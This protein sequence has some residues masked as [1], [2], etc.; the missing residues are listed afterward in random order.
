[1]IHPTSPKLA[2]T[3]MNHPYLKF[4]THLCCVC[5]PAFGCCV[6]PKAGQTTFLSRFQLNLQEKDEQAIVS[7]W[8]TSKDCE[9]DL[10]LNYKT[11]G[12]P[13]AFGGIN[14]IYK[15]LNLRWDFKY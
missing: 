5:R 14:N 8:Q 12:H 6:H 15:S 10:N 7:N 9:N 4:I 3:S 11:P 1:M 13:I 2:A